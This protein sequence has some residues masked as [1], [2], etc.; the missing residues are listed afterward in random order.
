ML[1]DV[2]MH[3]LWLLVPPKTIFNVEKNENLLH[4]WA[5]WASKQIKT[6]FF[7]PSGTFRPVFF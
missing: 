1:F 3:I 6:I 4:F 7:P 5:K 2:F